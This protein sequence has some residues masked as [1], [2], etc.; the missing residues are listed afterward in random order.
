MLVDETGE[1]FEEKI[2]GSEKKRNKQTHKH[3]FL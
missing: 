3:R 2:E 1:M